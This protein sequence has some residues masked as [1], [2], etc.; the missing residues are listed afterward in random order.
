MLVLSVLALFLWETRQG[1]SVQASRTAAVNMLVIG[2]CVYLLNCRHRS[3]SAFSRGCLLGNRYALF[4]IGLA[5][6]LQML[7]TY[8]PL[9]QGFFGTRGIDPG[10]WGRI[11]LG[12][13]VIFL[14]VEGEKALISRSRRSHSNR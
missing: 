7:M 9:M 2:E 6:G 12:G 8:V 1:G 11:L 13:M 14:L 5:I 10:A 3:Q 4:A